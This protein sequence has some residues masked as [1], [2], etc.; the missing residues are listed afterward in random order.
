MEKLI[1]TF[2]V[3]LQGIATCVASEDHSTD[4]FDVTYKL[5]FARDVQHVFG[6]TNAPSASADQKNW[7]V[8]VFGS[9]VGK[10]GMM[11]GGRP[12]VEMRFFSLQ[13]KALNGRTRGGWV[14][15]VKPL[16][17]LVRL[18]SYRGELADLDVKY[19]TSVLMRK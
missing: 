15:A 19:E 16:F 2:I 7:D 8:Y 12:M 11:Q 5:M 17:F 9:I 18:G 14:S 6:M 4:E 10:K 1:I 13:K 3:I